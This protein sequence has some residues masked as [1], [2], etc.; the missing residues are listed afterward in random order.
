MK[1]LIYPLLAALILVSFSSCSKEGTDENYY[2]TFKKDGTEV[3]WTGFAKGEIGPDGFDSSLV[4]LGVTGQSPDGAERFDITLQ[5]SGTNFSTGMY[6]T[7]SMY[8]VMGYITSFNTV[9]P[10]IYRLGFNETYTEFSSYHVNITSITSTSIQ[11]TFSGNFLSTD[12]GQMV[13]ITEG[14]FRVKRVR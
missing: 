2:L 11:G 3:S 6:H 12:N 10:K 1:K 8:I 5:K 9:T 14:S 7:D 4:D 13:N